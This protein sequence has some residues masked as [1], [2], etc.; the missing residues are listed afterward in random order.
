V[1]K[2]E[3]NILRFDIPLDGN[4]ANE[5]CDPKILHKTDMEIT[6]FLNLLIEKLKDYD[7]CVVHCKFVYKQFIRHIYNGD[8]DII[9]EMV[10]SEAEASSLYVQ[11]IIHIDKN[12]SLKDVERLCANL[13][14]ELTQKRFQAFKN[15]DESFI[16][17][18]MTDI[19]VS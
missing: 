4:L 9:N 5:E 16:R 6:N 15:E 3:T 7:V 18:Y 19:I 1:Q 17:I 8:I 10:I 12:L 14:K 2:T 11:I 13:S